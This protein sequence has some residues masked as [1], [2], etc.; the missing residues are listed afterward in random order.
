MFVSDS[1]CFLSALSSLNVLFSVLAV[2]ASAINPNAD[3]TVIVALFSSSDV[4]K[5]MNTRQPLA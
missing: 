5:M 3:I 1:C 2:Q 4:I